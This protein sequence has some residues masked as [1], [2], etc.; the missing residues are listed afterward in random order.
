MKS[1]NEHIPIAHLVVA[2]GFYALLP[3]VMEEGK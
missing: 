1:P 3:Y 2:S